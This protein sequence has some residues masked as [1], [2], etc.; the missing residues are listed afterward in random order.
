MKPLPDCMRAPVQVSFLTRKAFLPGRIY[1]HGTD[2]SAVE[3]I[4][5]P[6]D[7]PELGPCLNAWMAIA[8]FARQGRNPGLALHSM[9]LQA[10]RLILLLLQTQWLFISVC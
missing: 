9:A 1:K 8:W 5:Q 6:G 10:W 2:F 3:S 7:L 4:Q